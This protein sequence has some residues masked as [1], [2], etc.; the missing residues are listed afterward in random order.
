M[1]IHVYKDKHSFVIGGLE[2]TKYNEYEILLEPG[3]MIFFYTDGLPEATN[4]SEEAFGIQRIIEALG[5]CSDAEPLD[6]LKIV[7]NAV[8]DFVLEA[9]QFD[10]LTML[11]LEYKGP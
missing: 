5:L 11:C 2:E 1:G 4:S 9:E 7:Q 3:M 6:V 8:D 10:D